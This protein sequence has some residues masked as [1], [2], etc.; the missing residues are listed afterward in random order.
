MSRSP[1]TFRG[2]ASAFNFAG[3]DYLLDL[4]DSYDLASEPAV[5][6]PA[7]TYDGGA[8]TEDGAAATHVYRTED[9]YTMSTATVWRGFYEFLGV[10]YPS[11]DVAEI[12]SV[13]IGPEG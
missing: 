13:L 10:T 2:M 12:R 3:Y 6:A 11:F 8:G 7:S 4:P 1:D 5:L 9:G